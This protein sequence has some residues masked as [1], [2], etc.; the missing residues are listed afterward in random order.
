MPALATSF[1]LKS[2]DAGQFTLEE[3]PAA[4]WQIVRDFADG[5]VAT[6]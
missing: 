2:P 3:Q 4:V 1:R 6:Q 5:G